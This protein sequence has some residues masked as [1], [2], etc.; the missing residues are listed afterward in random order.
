MSI[1]TTPPSPTYQAATWI[2]FACQS[3]GIFVTYNWTLYCAYNQPPDRPMLIA[4]FTDRTIL[5]EMSLRLRST[6]T[7]CVDTVVCSARDIVT[8]NTGNA[9]WTLG[10]VTGM[11]IKLCII[12]FIGLNL[13][14]YC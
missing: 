3:T 2:Q 5:G 12:K 8:G 4:Q 7:S 13:Y 11:H 1:T 10:M 14:L 6:P 9:T